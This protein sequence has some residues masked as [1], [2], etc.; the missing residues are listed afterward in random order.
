MIMG[1]NVEEQTPHCA[2]LILSTAFNL[3]KS[4]MYMS[5]ERM[6]AKDM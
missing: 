1:S 6:V 5:T 3:V 2:F 4:L